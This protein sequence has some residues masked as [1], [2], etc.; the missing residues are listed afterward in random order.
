MY[1]DASFAA[2]SLFAPEVALQKF[3][4]SMT[5]QF[6]TG[7]LVG[8]EQ[9]FQYQASR[10]ATLEDCK[11]ASTRQARKRYH[12]DDVQF[13]EAQVNGKRR[14]VEATEKLTSNTKLDLKYSPAPHLLAHASACTRCL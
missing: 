13:H 14:K 11:E 7:R 8:R 4:C 5:T 3:V 2:G 12:V 6:M 10:P 1:P 9:E